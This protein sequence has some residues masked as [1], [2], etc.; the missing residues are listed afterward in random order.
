MLIWTQTVKVISQV[1]TSYKK[2]IINLIKPLVKVAKV[3]RT[4]RPSMTIRKKTPSRHSRTL[5][6]IRR[7]TTACKELGVSHQRQSKKF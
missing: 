4:S 7:R 2:L 1:T 5:S 3:M 6:K